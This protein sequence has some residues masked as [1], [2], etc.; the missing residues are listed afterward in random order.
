ML[1]RPVA[2][3]TGESL[4]SYLPQRA[5]A[6]HLTLTEVLAVLPSWLSTKI[7]NP[8]ELSQHHMLVPATADALHALA[9]LARTTPEHLPGALPAFGATNA[10]GPVRATTAARPAA[11]LVN[12]SQ[13][14]CL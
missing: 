1:P 10:R 4:S 8:D 2:P 14:I 11:A 3:I 9:H 12:P 7:N 13:S 5:Q 6:N